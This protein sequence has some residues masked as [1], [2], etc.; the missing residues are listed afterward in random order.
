[1]GPDGGPDLKVKG[2]GGGLGGGRGGGAG[3][4]TLFGGLPLALGP[5]APSIP[6]EVL[7]PD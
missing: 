5:L 1:M 3:G 7:S 4:Q 6:L 2:R